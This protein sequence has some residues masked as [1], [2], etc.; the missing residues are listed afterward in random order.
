MKPQKT[1]TMVL[2]FK[3]LVFITYYVKKKKKKNTHTYIYGDTQIWKSPWCWERL[4]AEEEGDRMRWLDGI[5]DSK[6]IS[7]SKLQVIVKDGGA[8]R[9]TCRP[10]GHKESNTT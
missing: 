1:Q 7:L 4:R 9:A 6:D 2:P 10:Q 8:W 5:I 3:G